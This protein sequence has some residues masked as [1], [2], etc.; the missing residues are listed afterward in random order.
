MK[1]KIEHFVSAKHI[2]DNPKGYI[3]QFGSALYIG[4]RI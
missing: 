1:L 2:L 4:P 3:N